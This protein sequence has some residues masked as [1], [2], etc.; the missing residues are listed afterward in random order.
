MDEKL[1][2]NPVPVWELDGPFLQH[3]TSCQIK[4]F[5]SGCIC[6]EKTAILGHLTQLTIKALYGIGGV[7]MPKDRVNLAIICNKGKLSA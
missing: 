1:R 6:W 7:A 5:Q 3:F 4:Q 2:Q